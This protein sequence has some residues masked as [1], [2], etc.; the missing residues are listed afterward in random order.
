LLDGILQLKAGSR[1]RCELS[2]TISFSIQ[3]VIDQR[4]IHL[5]KQPGKV[6]LPAEV[7]I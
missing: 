2:P 6:V 1:R 5:P 4:L 3:L 7:S